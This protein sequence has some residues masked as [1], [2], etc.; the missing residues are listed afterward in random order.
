VKKRTKVLT[1]I[2]YT[3]P[4]VH[5]ASCECGG[6]A[7]EE[8]VLTL[9]PP[10]SVYRAMNAKNPAALAWK[11]TIYRGCKLRSVKITDPV[12]VG[13]L[14]ACS[15]GGAVP[16]LMDAIQEVLPA[17]SPLAEFAVQWCIGPLHQQA[18]FYC[19]YRAAVYD[20]FAESTCGPYLAE[21]LTRAGEW[22][23]VSTHPTPREAQP[24]AVTAMWNGLRPPT[25]AHAG[26]RVVSACGRSY[27]EEG[28]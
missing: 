14:D 2:T 18:V 27:G 12:L 9:T 17:K 1:G 24:A 5:A 11:A 10:T 21:Y 16:M 8:W 23:S 13:L 20:H 7:A 19:K 6:R 3:I 25:P 22:V 28:Q 15:P 4:V 26:W